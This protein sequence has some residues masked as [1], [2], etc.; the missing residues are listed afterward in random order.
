MDKRSTMFYANITR[1]LNDKGMK[2]VADALI[3]EY[4]PR[5]AALPAGAASPAQKH[6]LLPSDCPQCGA[7]IHVDKA[8]RADSSTVECAYCG[9]QIRL[10]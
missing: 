3:S 2:N 1:K 6:G 4:G 7:P 9:S 5:I 8:G 10:D